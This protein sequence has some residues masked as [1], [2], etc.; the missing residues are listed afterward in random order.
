[1]NYRD[2]VVELRV[3]TLVY[4]NENVHISD[5]KKKINCYGKLPITIYL[6]I[7]NLISLLKSSQI[8]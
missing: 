2:R 1:M 5:N 4:N 8:F 3:K 7:T 6:L